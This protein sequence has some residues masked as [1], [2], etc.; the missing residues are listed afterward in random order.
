MMGNLKQGR[1]GSFAGRP[2]MRSA[3][4]RHDFFLSDWSDGACTVSGGKEIA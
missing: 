3:A 1:K 4:Q 2:E